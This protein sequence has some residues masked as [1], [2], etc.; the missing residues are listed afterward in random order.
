MALFTVLAR[1]EPLTEP[2]VVADRFRWSAFLFA[3]V[4]ALLHGLW[5]TMLLLVAVII[6]LD[7]AAAFIGGGAAVL[8]YVLIAW[9]YALESPALERARWR[10]RGFFLE[11]DRIASSADLAAVDWLRRG[12]SR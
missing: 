3:P 10:R 8:L 6:G 7:F 12:A 4:H 9:L 2:A 1:P 11:A 5:V